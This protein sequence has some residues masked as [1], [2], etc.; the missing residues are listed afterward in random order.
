MANDAVIEQKVPSGK[1]VGI[2][3]DL[4][5]GNEIEKFSSINIVEGSDV[6]NAKL[7]LPN[8]FLECT[9][10]GASNITKCDGHF[11]CIKLPMTIYNPHLVSEIVYLLNQICPGCKSFKTIL[12]LK[13]KI[14]SSM[15][16]KCLMKF[17]KSKLFHKSPSILVPPKYMKSSIN[18]KISKEDNQTGCKYCNNTGEWYPKVRFKIS[19]KDVQGNKGLGIVAE[20]SKKLPRKFHD[21]KLTDVLPKDYWSFI[22]MYPNDQGTELKT[23]SPAQAFFFIKT[24]S[25]GDHQ[26]IRSEEG[27]NVPFLCSN[28]S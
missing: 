24:P 5:T 25:S 1:L 28:L 6:T 15:K 22:P 3:F 16:K 9:T 2:K 13:R 17:V 26:E 21:R 19:L 8:T 4:L 11:G 10:C 12:Q 18:E 14:H 23:I 27:V 7:G 20:I